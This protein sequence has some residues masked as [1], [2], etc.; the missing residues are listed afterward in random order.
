MAGSTPS[1]SLVKTLAKFTLAGVL[2]WEVGIDPVY[3][4]AV[5]KN[6]NIY[7]GGPV[8]HEGITNKIFSPDGDLLHQF[9]FGSTVYSMALKKSSR[10][11]FS[12]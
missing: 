3:A 12:K 10:Y 4:I 6:G 1:G 9:N 11:D 7:T 8:N 2:V 5:D